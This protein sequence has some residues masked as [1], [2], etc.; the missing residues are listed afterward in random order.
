MTAL[1]PPPIQVRT[2][3]VHQRIEI[4]GDGGVV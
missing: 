1:N 2:E 4:A 3:Q